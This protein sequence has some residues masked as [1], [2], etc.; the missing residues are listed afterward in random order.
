M[1]DPSDQAELSETYR[2]ETTVRR[3]DTDGRVLSETTTLVVA[4]TKD[5]C[6]EQTGMYL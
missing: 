6:D 4:R 1:S 2:I 3:L 5:G